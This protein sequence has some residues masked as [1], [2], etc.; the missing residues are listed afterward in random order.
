M[1]FAQQ[2]APC[3]KFRPHPAQPKAWV[4]GFSLIEVLVAIVVLSIGLL[5]LAGLQT[6][7]IRNSYASYQRSLANLQTQD[8]VE[9]LWVNRCA[10]QRAAVLNTIQTEW[11]T[12]HA[13]ASNRVA[14]PD[15]TGSI[16]G[17]END[18]AA[19][20]GRYLISITWTERATLQSQAGASLTF[21][22]AVS[23]PFNNCTP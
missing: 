7:A 4:G 13:A 6:A 3:T 5:S 18:P 23:I 10:L 9:R 20:I 15:W 14:M 19:T 12:A 21:S 8:A 17:T 1:S 16:T 2:A 11:R 22:H